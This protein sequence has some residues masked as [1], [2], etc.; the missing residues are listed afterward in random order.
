MHFML[1]LELDNSKAYLTAMGILGQ[2]NA[3]SVKLHHAK[4]YTTESLKTMNPFKF[5]ASV[6]CHARNSRAAR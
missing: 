4:R 6:T 1:L 5:Q 2:L 3:A